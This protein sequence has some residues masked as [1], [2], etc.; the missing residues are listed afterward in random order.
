MAEPFR[1][2]ILTLEKSVYDAD[3][4][5]IIAPGL[6]GYFGVLAH[7]AP[8]TAALKPG[9]LTVVD[10]QGVE[11]IYAVSGGFFEV[12]GNVATLLAD[13]VEQACD[14]DPSRAEA[15]RER[16]FRMLCSVPVGPDAIAARAAFERATNRI[17]VC[18][19][20]KPE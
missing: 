12:A 18:R 17:Q 2:K 5:S 7:H 15:A 9:K 20:Q 3:V 6:E 14:I 19:S 1:L 16:A 4:T 11:R 8:M 10:T 13:A